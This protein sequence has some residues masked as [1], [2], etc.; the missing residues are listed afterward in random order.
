MI[1]GYTYLKNAQTLGYPFIESILS[2]LSICDEFIIALGDCDDDT[3]QYIKN[4]NSPKIVIIHTVWNKENLN[5]GT[6]FA[7]QAKIALDNCKYDWVLHLQ[8]DEVIHQSDLPKI[9]SITQKHINNNQVEGFLFPYLHFYGNYNYICASPRWY[10]NEIRLFRN[11][12]NVRPY[13]DSQGFRIENRKI[14]VLKTDISV[15]HYSRVSNPELLA[16]KLQTFNKMYN[17][18]TKKQIITSKSVDFDQN[19]EFLK[20]FWGSHPL[21]MNER[22]NNINWNF[23]YNPQKVRL[24][25]KYWFKLYIEKIT[26]YLPFEY[27]NYEIIY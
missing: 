22:I 17:S 20:E 9:I 12:I 18:T 3:E 5:G 11:R 23:N 6:E 8:C 16:K 24:P 1:S 26:G 2:V 25:V 4:I 27:K 15:F 14:R 13:R 19:G 10:R 21:I 7:R